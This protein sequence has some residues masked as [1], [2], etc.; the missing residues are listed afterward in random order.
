MADL[1]IAHLSVRQA[2]M[3]ALGVDQGVRAGGPQPVPVGDIGQGQRVVAWVLPVAPAIEDQQDDRF[4]ARGG[5][6]HDLG[7]SDFRQ[8]PEWG[9]V[10]YTHL[11]HAFRAIGI[12][13]RV[14][15]L[16][17]LRRGV[18][19]LLRVGLPGQQQRKDKGKRA[20]T[21]RALHQP[22]ECVQYAR[23]ARL[24]VERTMKTG[25]GFS[26]AARRSG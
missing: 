8:V 5:F 22:D 7:T 10:S 17:L 25:R 20:K 4:R 19:L 26:D 6:M 21:H 16:P 24:S 23:H 2:D 3:A 18:G 13:H 11:G 14:D 9:P 1:G 12:V 15:V